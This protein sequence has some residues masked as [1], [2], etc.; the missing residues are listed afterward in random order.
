MKLSNII[1]FELKHSKYKIIFF[2]VFINISLLA[3]I[4]GEYFFT[5]NLGFYMS[6]NLEDR[7]IL[8]QELAVE[9]YIDFIIPSIAS[10]FILIL[11]SEDYTSNIYEILYVYS[12]SNYNKFIL[13]RWGMT[14]LIFFT[15]SILYS[16]LILSKTRI[17]GDT[18]NSNG[19]FIFDLNIFSILIKSIPTLLWY[20]VMPLIILKL[21]KN[22]Y[23]CF[24]IIVVY[25]FMDSYCFLYIYPFGAMW[26]ANSYLVMKQFC[27][28][29]GNKVIGLDLFTLQFKFILNRIMFVL[30]SCLGLRY[31]IKNK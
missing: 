27:I 4:L 11:M 24:C 5:Y 30:I 13:V 18:Y 14:F 17:I 29:E 3:L 26:N 8:V 21:I 28:Y 2:M 12:T 23:I 22:P 1:E 31:T 20:T 7:Y 16:I 9:K 25:I 19:I 6:L 10:I 15:M